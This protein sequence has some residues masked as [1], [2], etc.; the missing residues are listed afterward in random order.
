MNCAGLQLSNNLNCVY[1]IS[2]CM[3]RGGGYP[4]SMTMQS[5]SAP[6]GVK[7]DALPLEPEHEGARRQSYSAGD[8]M[9]SILEKY[10][11]SFSVQ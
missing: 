4:Q 7:S 6:K 8:R 9:A 2:N 10:L 11:I 3:G 5:G 1:Q